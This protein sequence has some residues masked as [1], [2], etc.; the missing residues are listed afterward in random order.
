MGN[1]G[2]FCTITP[3]N[4]KQNPVSVREFLYSQAAVGR[5]PFS[6]ATSSSTRVTETEPTGPLLPLDIDHAK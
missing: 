3:W 4:I 5:P 1:A 6:T 2:D